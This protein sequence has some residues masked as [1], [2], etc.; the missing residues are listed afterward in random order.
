MRRTTAPA[1]PGIALRRRPLGTNGTPK[2]S[3]S[4]ATATSFRFDSRR[5]TSRTSARLIEP[6]MRTSTLVRWVREV[7]A[8]KLLAL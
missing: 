3:A 4:S 8:V 5:A 1:A 7:L 6:G 2:R